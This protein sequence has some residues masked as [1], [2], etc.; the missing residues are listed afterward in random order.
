MVLLGF[1]HEP[2]ASS[3]WVAAGLTA[4]AV[5][6]IGWPARNSGRTSAKGIGPGHLIGGVFQPARFDGSTF[7]PSDGPGTDVILYFWIPGAAHA[8]AF[9]MA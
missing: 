8:C 5:A 3:T 7:Q 9:A 4:I 2:L 1:S 6:L